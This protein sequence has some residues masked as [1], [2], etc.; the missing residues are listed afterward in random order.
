MTLMNEA[1][2]RANAAVTDA[3]ARRKTIMLAARAEKER[4]MLEAEGL[5]L[6]I[7]TL[8]GAVNSGGDGGDG[9][10][11]TQ[12]AVQFL[13]LIRYMET[14]AK[15]AQSDNTKVVMLPSKDSL[16]LTYGGLKFLID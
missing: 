14:Q 3:E 13:S 9:L 4:Q 5:K 8:A 12:V 16:P 7:Q 15:F 2:G 10:D 6:A 11:P 1:E